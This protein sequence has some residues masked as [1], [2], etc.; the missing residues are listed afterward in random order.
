MENIEWNERGFIPG[1]SETEETFAA[2]AAKLANLTKQP[3]HIPLE[4]WSEAL[5]TT[6]RL[7]DIYPDWIP[8]CYSDRGL[9]FWEG[10]AT[11]V[12]EDGSLTVQLRKAFR[13]GS[14]LKIYSRHEILA[15]EAV[16]SARVALGSTLFEEILAY[17]T[18]TSRLRRWAGPFFLRPWES[19]LFAILL[20]FGAACSIFSPLFFLLPILGILCGAIRLSRL[21]LLFNKCLKNIAALSKDPKK[22]LAVAIRLTDE[23]IID[24]AYSTPE[25]ITSY[26]T[27]EKDRTLRWKLLSPYFILRAEYN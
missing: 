12:Q 8:S 2:R 21:W 3:D 6:R 18:S 23:E 5:S 27:Q 9:R 25:E 22:K 19:V 13:K 24:F 17:S 26:I 15:H 7:F 14:Y 10:A 20:L 16:H 11:W 1:P 4:D